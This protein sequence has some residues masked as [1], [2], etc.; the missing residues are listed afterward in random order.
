[1]KC[2]K[3]Q[4]L[5]ILLLILLIA[6]LLVLAYFLYQMIPGTPQSMNVSFLHTPA[7]GNFSSD[8][9][10]FYP[11]M[12]FNHNRISY[13]ID[14]ACSLDEIQRVQEAF[15]GLEDKVDS[16][17]FYEI[18]GGADI[19]VSCSQQ[20]EKV[21]KDFFIA[22]EG[23]AREIIQT[24]RFN[25]ITNGTVLLYTS[26]VGFS[27]CSWP[28]VETHEILHV[29]GFMHSSNKNSIMYPYLEGCNQQ[30]DASIIE[31]LK[32]LYSQDNL[33]DLG[34]DNV[35][36]VKKGIYLDFNATVKNF[37][38]VD[39]DSVILGVLDN[40][41]KLQDFNLK[42]IPYGASIVY[43]VSNLKL[44]SRASSSVEMVIDPDNRI[45]EIDES[46]NVAYLSF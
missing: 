45:R 35:N 23:G 11:N 41:N 31:Q 13:D 4:V 24:D 36:A 25:V 8:V 26:P 15:K 28:N 14:S 30:I 37:G 1:M 43:T 7:V 33:P 19:D 46:N 22:G 32:S 38:D 6:A 3:A 29:F 16:I 10:Q 42:N 20:K 5:I 17:S 27:D 9:K 2:K 21:Q 12:K 39:A 40:G 18:N 34:F 44:D